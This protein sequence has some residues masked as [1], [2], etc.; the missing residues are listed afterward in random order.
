MLV[1]FGSGT[2]YLFDAA[3]QADGKI[4][5]VGDN[6]GMSAVLRFLAR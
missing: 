5:T 6:G 4:V 1:H 3:S 2:D